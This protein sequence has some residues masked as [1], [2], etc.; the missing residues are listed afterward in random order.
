VTSGERDPNHGFFKIFLFTG[1]HTKMEQIQFT[2]VE[3]SDSFGK[4]WS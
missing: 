2:Q 4:D 1:L 3:Q